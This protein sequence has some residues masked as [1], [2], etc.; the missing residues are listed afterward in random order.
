[1]PRVHQQITV[2][3]PEGATC[4]R[5]QHK[6]M[7]EEALMQLSNELNELVDQGARKVVLNLGPDDPIVLYSVFLAKL[8]SFQ[9]RLRQVGGA[10]KLA[11]VGPQ[12]MEIFKVCR[13]VELFEF[14]PD[15]QAALA[16]F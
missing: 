9:K 16:T 14:Y 4:V 15:Q 6:K 3:E 8:V 11:A 1:M 13:L 10:L 12:T 5:L 7:D 2:E